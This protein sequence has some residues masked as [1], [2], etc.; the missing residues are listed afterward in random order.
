[1][2]IEQTISYGKEALIDLALLYKNK[3]S[4]RFDFILEKGTNTYRLT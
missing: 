3:D 2:A 4:R 1:M